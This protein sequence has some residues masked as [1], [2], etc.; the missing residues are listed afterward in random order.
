MPAVIHILFCSHFSFLCLCLLLHHSRT[1]RSLARFGIVITTTIRRTATDIVTSS[2]TFIHS[3]ITHIRTL[4]ISFVHS[5]SRFRFACVPK[6]LFTFF[7]FSCRHL[8]KYFSFWRV[9]CMGKYISTNT[10]P[11]HN[12]TC[13]IA[14][15]YIVSMNLIHSY[16][17][18]NSFF[19]KNQIWKKIIMNFYQ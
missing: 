13:R 3:F 9:V 1:F 18:P 12:D 17:H 8:T 11:S 2:L 19:G 5:F 16:N 15:L 10:L 4:S 6:N 14:Y 7:F